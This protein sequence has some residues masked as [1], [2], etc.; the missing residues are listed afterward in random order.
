MR[1][2]D[3]AG[4]RPGVRARQADD[5]RAL[6]VVAPHP[7]R[8][9]PWIRDFALVGGVSGFSAPFAMLRFLDYSLV[10]GLGGLLGGAALGS[11]SAWL[12]NRQARRWR[13]FVL[14][15]LG[16]C[17][18]ALWGATAGGATAL[19]PQL[20]NLLELSVIVAAIAGAVQLGWFWLAYSVRRVNHRSTWPVVLVASALGGGL[21]WLAVFGLSVLR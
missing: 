19:V 10:T 21:G 12:I 13:R 9:W 5:M 1:P 16:L 18:G 17:F 8:P 4:A 7:E 6:P 3:P 15:P 2:F 11:L 14:L 20:R